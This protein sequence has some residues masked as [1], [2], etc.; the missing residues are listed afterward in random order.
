MSK[1][2]MIYFIATPIGNLADITLRALDTLRSV[3]RVFAEDTRV[4]QRLLQHYDIDKKVTSYHKFNEKQR[5]DMILE[6]QEAGLTVAVVSDAGMPCLQD[7]GALLI[8]SLREHGVAFTVIP[9]AN[10]AAMAMALTG[11]TSSS[12]S[13][14]GFIPSKASEK[15]RFFT[16]VRNSEDAVICYESMLRVQDSLASAATIL[17]AHCEVYFAKELTKCHECSIKTTVAELQ[18]MIEEGTVILKGEL[19]LIFVPLPPAQEVEYHK[20]F[21]VVSEHCSAKDAMMITQKLTGVSR[22]T[23]YRYAKT[24]LSL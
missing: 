2:V 15:K 8:Q 6:T 21:D 1:S 5:I 19:V 12:Y 4:C 16:A 11:L 14:R 20:V 18:A 10:A 22:N 23:I 24:R 13:F 7:P 17:G 9:G 3:D